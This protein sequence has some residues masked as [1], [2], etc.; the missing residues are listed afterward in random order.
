MAVKMTM[1]SG[2]STDAPGD[3]HDCNGNVAKM[4]SMACMV[5]CVTPALAALPHTSRVSL[6]L[7]PTKPVLPRVS[8]LLGKDSRPDPYPPRASDIG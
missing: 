8:S 5:T 4:K 2:M 6:A 3:C 7:V 1:A